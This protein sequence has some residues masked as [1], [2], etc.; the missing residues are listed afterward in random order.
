MSG[1]GQS[2]V[3]IG[4]IGSYEPPAA[5]HRSGSAFPKPRPPAPGTLIRG[6]P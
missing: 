4:V 6:H 5:S 2:A 1:Q 3:L